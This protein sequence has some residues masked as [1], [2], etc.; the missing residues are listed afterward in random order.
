M[1]MIEIDPHDRLR[2]TAEPK[3]SGGAIILTALLL[4][5]GTILGLG[6]FYW[7]YISQKSNFVEVYKQIDI[8]PLPIAVERLPQVLARL[9]QLNREPCYRDAITGLSDA[10]RNAGY[11][12]ESAVSALSFARRCGDTEN[13]QILRRAYAGFKDVSDFSSALDVANRLVKSDPADAD[14]RYWRGETYEQLNDYSKALPDYLNTLQLLGTPSRVH[15]NHFYDISRM[16]AALGRHCDGISPLETYISF[17]PV[18][19]R[20]SQLTKIIAEYAEKGRCDTNYARGVARVPLLGATGVSTLVVIINGVAGNFILDTG[21][22]YVAVTPDF[23]AKAKIRIELS[24]PLPVKTVGGSAFA[25]IGYA[26]TVSVGSATAE[27][28]VVAVIRGSADPFG[29]HLDGLL[30]MSFLARFKLQVSPEGIDLA[31]IPLR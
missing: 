18:R 3:R 8:P 4:V 22:T 30:G 9:D 13:I 26:T 12:R 5:V 7:Q 6:I 23:S 17:D 27:G 28:V 10:L 31:A 21:A 2:H 25:D 15:V 24:D 20:T 1:R 19:N 29:G 16:Y 14:Y 11:P